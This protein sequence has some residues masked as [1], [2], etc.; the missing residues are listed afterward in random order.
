MGLSVGNFFPVCREQSHRSRK[1]SEVVR[2][3]LF[4]VF[5][6]S[7]GWRGG[8]TTN[9]KITKLG[10]E[11]DKKQAKLFSTFLS[12]PQLQLLVWSML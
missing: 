11:L 8:Q 1:L 4:F 7:F 2:R 9:P 6:F 10:S 5:L 12:L 3:K